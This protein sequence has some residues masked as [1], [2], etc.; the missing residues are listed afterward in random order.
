GL[1][2]G[3]LVVGARLPSL[4]VTLGTM[5]LFRGVAMVVSQGQPV[6]NFPE[7][8]SKLGRGEWMGM[9]VQLVIWVTLTLV[10]MVI[11]DRS[12]AGR[13]VVAVG[14]NPLAARYAALPERT[15]TLALYLATGLLTA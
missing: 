14:D 8:F 13:Y 10:A 7:G 3:G 5:A 2:N 12:R 11:A 15:V 9:P 4:V 1:I 6:S